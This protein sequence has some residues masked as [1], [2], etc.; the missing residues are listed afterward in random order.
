MLFWAQIFS[1]FYWVWMFWE[2]QCFAVTGI[3]LSV[4]AFW[5]SFCGIWKWSALFW[6]A[7][8]LSAAFLWKVFA[9]GE[10]VWCLTG[11]DSRV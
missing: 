5:M 4:V 8:G 7:W 10:A 6:S 1:L 2:C 3:V 11:W 9:A